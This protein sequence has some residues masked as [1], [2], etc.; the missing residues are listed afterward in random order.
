M[1]QRITKLAA[2]VLLVVTAMPWASHAAEEE[3]AIV[4]AS[5]TSTQDSGLFGFL[6]PVVRERT[7]VTAKVVALGT[8]QA[9]ETARRGDADVVFV[10]DAEAEARFVAEGYGL[11]RYP[12][13]YNDF[14]IVGPADDPAGIRGNK[15]VV[16]ALLAIQRRQSP[17]VSR[18]DKSGTHQAELRLW[19]AAGIA[20]D[21][22][23]DRWYRAVG[24][25][26]GPALNIA[27]ASDAYVLTDRATWISFRNKQKFQTL[28]EGDPR[29]FNQYSLILVNPAKHPGTK[30]AA[31][32]KFIDFLLSPEGQRVLG[33]YRVEGQQLFHPNA[34]PAAR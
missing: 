4:V 13:M 32:Q 2:T 18:G 5:T 14:I 6:L 9:L 15:D 34:S 23:T 12:V 28:V 30:V 31:G 25:G 29:L 20:I 8:G 33:S 16:R 27:V 22:A 26:M 11:V 17:F 19:S 10:H 1:K 24:Q 7:G 21:S 3:P